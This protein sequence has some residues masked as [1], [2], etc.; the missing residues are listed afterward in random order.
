MINFIDNYDAMK[1]KIYSVHPSDETGATEITLEQ[2]DTLADGINSNLT[3]L[4]EANKI[5]LR[6]VVADNIL[7]RAHECIISNVNTEYDLV[8]YIDTVDEDYDEDIAKDA[9]RIVKKFNDIISV[10]RKND[11]TSFFMWIANSNI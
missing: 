2:I 1:T 8:H 4:L 3:N 7:G 10:I 6:S 5:I 11:W 9:M